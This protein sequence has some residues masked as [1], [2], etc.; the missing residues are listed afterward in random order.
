MPYDNDYNRMISRDIDYFNR[1]YVMHCSTTGQGTIDYRAEMSGGCN[2]CEG[3]GAGSKTFHSGDDSDEEMSGGAILGIQSGTVLG[4]PETA[5]ETRRVIS[6]FSSLGAPIG[7]SPNAIN[8]PVSRA[9]DAPPPSAQPVGAPP[10]GAPPA[11]APG[12]PPAVPR[13]GMGGAIL[14]PLKSYENRYMY[15]SPNFS[16][17]PVKDMR[18]VKVSLSS[19]GRPDMPKS[20]MT[21]KAGAEVYVRDLGNG[22]SDSDE[23]YTGAGEYESSSSDSSSEYSSSEEEGLQRREHNETSQAVKRARNYLDGGVCSDLGYGGV[24][25]TGFKPKPAPAP[26]PKPGGPGKNEPGKGPGDNVSAPPP[27]GG[28]KPPKPP[29]A[30][31]GPPAPGKGPGGPGK[32]PG[33]PGKGPSD[34]SKPTKAEKR[35]AKREAERQA[36]ENA[37]QTPAPN[38][39]GKQSAPAAPAAPA[40]ASKPGAPQANPSGPS[41]LTTANKAIDLGLAVVQVINGFK[42]FSDDPAGDFLDF[43]EDELCDDLGPNPKIEDIIQCLQDQGYDDEEIQ[44]LL[45]LSQGAIGEQPGKEVSQSL[46]VKHDERKYGNKDKNTACMDAMNGVGDAEDKPSAEEKPVRKQ[47]SYF[48]GYFKETVNATEGQQRF[49]TVNAQMNSRIGFGKPIVGK[50]DNEGQPSRKARRNAMVPVP[51][52]KKVAEIRPPSP[53]RPK[54]PPQPPQ[55]QGK[56]KPKVGKGGPLKLPEMKKESC[57]PVEGSGKKPNKRAEIVKKIMKEKGLK[58]IDAS[59]YVKEHNLY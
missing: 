50:G 49:P 4:G 32:G 22:D 21:N 3:G 41:W 15:N 28:P 8:N 44:N 54:T 55:P 36:K 48:G 38:K 35:K 33:G 12:A 1:K 7:F 34:S 14:G 52:P 45:S 47:A 25:K 27:P 39:P 42:M 43:Y 13:V 2:S 16:A 46:K 5:R 19:L 59:K 10:A 51:V 58:M 40:A 6:S 56:G 37:P 57:K 31:P 11:G 30:P 18:G 20:G 29:S 23:G 9:Q 26:K 24:R 53:L 17:A